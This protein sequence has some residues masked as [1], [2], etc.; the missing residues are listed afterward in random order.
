MFEF[1]FAN[2]LEDCPAELVECPGV[3]HFECFHRVEKA[4]HVFTEAEDCGAGTLRFA[5]CLVTTNSFECCTTVVE[6]VCENVCAGFLPRDE[7]ALMPDIFCSFHLTD[8]ES[9]PTFLAQIC[10]S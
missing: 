8:V 9:V 4:F 7:F 10:I 2:G 5:A 1:V 3:F 6:R